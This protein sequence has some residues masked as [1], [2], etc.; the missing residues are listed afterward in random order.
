[1]FQIDVTYPSYEEEVKIVQTTTGTYRPI[2]SKILDSNK[3][4]EYQELST[5]FRFRTTSL[6]T[7]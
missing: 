3:I 6:P 1:M 7:Q 2:L 5:G 4:L